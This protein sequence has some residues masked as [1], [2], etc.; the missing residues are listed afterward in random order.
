MEIGPK[1]IVK[2]IDASLLRT[3]DTEM[4]LQMLINTA[5]KYNFYCVYALSCY[6]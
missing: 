3:V 1:D 6:L 2:M 5:K 4:D